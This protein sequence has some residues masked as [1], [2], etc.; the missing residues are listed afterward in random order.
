MFSNGRAVVSTIG[1]KESRADFAKRVHRAVNASVNLHS[2]LKAFSSYRGKS[3]IPTHRTLCKMELILGGKNCSDAL[4]GFKFGGRT[5]AEDLEGII[6][7]AW[8]AY[9]VWRRNGETS[10]Q[11][12]TV[13]LEEAQA[14]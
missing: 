12:E 2:E 9:D 5:F 4:K 6:G 11:M 10:I 1:A 14:N 13:N 3:T 8:K 7:A